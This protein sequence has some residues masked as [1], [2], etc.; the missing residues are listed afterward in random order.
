M[1][2]K[3]WDNAKNA[4]GVQR[5]NPSFREGT[6]VVKPWLQEG[7]RVELSDDR[8][9]FIVHHYSHAYLTSEHRQ[10]LKDIGRLHGT[11]CFVHKPISPRRYWKYQVEWDDGVGRTHA[12]SHY[13]LKPIP[14]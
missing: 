9:H 2:K 5:P 3:T 10:K 4:R 7:D 11:V 12:I 13:D 6:D 8:F 1:D 14:Q